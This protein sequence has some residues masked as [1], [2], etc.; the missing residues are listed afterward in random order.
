MRKTIFQ[1]P[2]SPKTNLRNSFQP[3]KDG[4]VEVPTLKSLTWFL[5]LLAV[6]GITND[7]KEALENVALWL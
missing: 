1:W 3:H 4:E 7:I 2:T 6:V 5:C